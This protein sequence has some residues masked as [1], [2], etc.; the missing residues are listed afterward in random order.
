MYFQMS[1][2]IRRVAALIGAGMLLTACGYGGYASSVSTSTGHVPTVVVTRD[3]PHMGKILT[4]SVGATVY[5]T[6]QEADGIT[7]C[8]QSCLKLWTPMIIPKDAPAHAAVENLGTVNRSDNGQNQVTYKGQPL[9]TFTLDSGAG[10]TSGL[11]APSDFDG[12]HF[13]WH[14]VVLDET[15]T[16]QGGF[17]L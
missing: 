6:D 1:L 5:F 9:Y 10:D 4:D 12:T 13:V 11:R 17:G 2:G 8:T 15:P 7:R 14:P 16:G 3:N